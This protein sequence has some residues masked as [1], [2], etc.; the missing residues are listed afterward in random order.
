MPIIVML[1][2]IGI[3]IAVDWNLIKNA[4]KI[5]IAT[6]IFI[7]GVCAILSFLPLEKMPGP[8]TLLNHLIGFLSVTS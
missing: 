7:F 8:T 5:E 2:L 6:L 4:S 3:I 1:I